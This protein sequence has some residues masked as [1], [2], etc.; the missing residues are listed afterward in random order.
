[1]NE[2]QKAR[3]GHQFWP[4]KAANLPALYATETTTVYEKV[5]R[6]HYFVGGC[7]W[8]LVELD[9]NGK[10]FGYACLGDPDNAEW[11]YIDLNELEAVKVGGLF[12]VERDCYWKPVTV[13][14]ANLPGQAW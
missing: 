8:W 5:I 7:D 3:R 9:A 4:T 14:E 13:G 6:A 1:M 10:A 2:T 12:V 11:G